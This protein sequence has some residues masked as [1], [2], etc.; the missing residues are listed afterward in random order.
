MCL[1]WYKL[2]YTIYLLLINVVDIKKLTHMLTDDDDT[3][4]VRSSS[5]RR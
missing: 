4:M 5:S 3:L 1:M 2:F